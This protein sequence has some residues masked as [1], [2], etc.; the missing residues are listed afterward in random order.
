MAGE[1]EELV[2]APVDFV[3]R[4]ALEKAPDRFARE[5][6]LASAVPLYGS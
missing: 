1:A 3:H 6:I 4:R 5:D 2:S